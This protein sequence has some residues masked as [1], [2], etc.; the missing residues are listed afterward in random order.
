MTNL[1][2]NTMKKLLLSL[3]SVILLFSCGNKID[4]QIE[5]SI[6]EICGKKCIIKTEKDK[7]TFEISYEDEEFGLAKQKEHAESLVWRLDK[8]MG[9][10]NSGVVEFPIENDGGMAFTYQWETPDKV[11]ALIY[12]FHKQKNGEYR[13]YEG[14]YEGNKTYIVVKYK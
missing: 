9:V 3:L 14:R 10:L 12:E 2:T 6:K 13:A 8:I 11:A 5:S 4:S 7:T 1:I